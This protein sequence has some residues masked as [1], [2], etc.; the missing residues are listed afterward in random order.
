M[1]IGYSVVRVNISR[2]GNN[3]TAPVKCYVPFVTTLCYNK[4]TITI[5]TLTKSVGSRIIDITLG[6]QIIVGGA[7]I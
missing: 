4:D 3:S 2:R 7:L 6:P 1:T 5:A